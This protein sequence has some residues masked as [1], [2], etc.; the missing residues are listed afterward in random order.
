MRNLWILI[1]LSSF[2]AL[3]GFAG[4]GLLEAGWRVRLLLR[5]RWAQ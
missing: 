1:V 5:H 2:L 4:S 3:T